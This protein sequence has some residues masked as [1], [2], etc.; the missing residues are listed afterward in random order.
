MAASRILSV[1]TTICLLCGGGTTT[2][3]GN[4]ADA[5][6]FYGGAFPNRNRTCSCYYFFVM[7]VW[8]FAVSLLLAVSLRLILSYYFL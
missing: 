1:F 6:G 7:A 5:F 2:D 8:F 3:R 4:G